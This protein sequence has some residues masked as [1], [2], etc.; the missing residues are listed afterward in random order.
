MDHQ[1]SSVKPTILVAPL[2]WGLGHATRCIPI[3]SAL[4][5]QNCNVLLAG[6]GK[7]KALLLQEFPQVNFLDLKGYQISYSKSKWTLPFTI[8]TQIPKIL[9]AVNYEHEW[10]EKTVLEHSIDAVIS[11]NRHGLY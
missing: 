2:D 3:I 4:I 6:E 8:T 1:N 7:I 9:A 10:L 5:H 11:D